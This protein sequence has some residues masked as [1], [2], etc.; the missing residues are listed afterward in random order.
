MVLPAAPSVLI[1]QEH[2]KG[3]HDSEKGEGGFTE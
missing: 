2:F 3:R 1:P